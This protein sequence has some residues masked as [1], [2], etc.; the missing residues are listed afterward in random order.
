MIVVAPPVGAVPPQLFG[1]LQLPSAVDVHVNVCPR[2]PNV[3]NVRMMH[4]Q[5]IPAFSN[6][7]RFISLL[8]FSYTARARTRFQML[9]HPR[10][11]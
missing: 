3:P 11:A 6:F 7:D 4:A 8:L 2:A 1:S 5:K 10:A 9:A